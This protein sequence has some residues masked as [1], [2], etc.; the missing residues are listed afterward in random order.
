MTARKTQTAIIA[1]AVLASLA[2]VECR[3]QSGAETPTGSATLG[4]ARLKIEWEAASGRK[5]DRSY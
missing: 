5:P 1:A 4:R 3:P 2:A